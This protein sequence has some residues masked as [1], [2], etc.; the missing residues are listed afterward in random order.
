GSVV[1]TLPKDAKFD[2]SAS[3]MNG[4]IASTFPLPV[5]AVETVAP[6]RGA[7]GSRERKVVVRTDEGD[8]EVDLRELE[9]ELEASMREA[10][11]AIEE[12]V[13]EGVLEAQ[14]ELRRIRVTDPRREYTG[15]VGKGGVDVKVETLN[16]T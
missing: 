13:R 9:Q 1:L 4:T 5:H 15:S 16:G 11:S 7:R 8:T 3:T 6:P 14:R 2:L 12:G 10:E